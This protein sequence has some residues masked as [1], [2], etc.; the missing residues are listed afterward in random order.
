MG[1]L[2]VVY[3]AQVDGLDGE[4]DCV[5]SGRVTHRGSPIKGAT[6]SLRAAQTPEELLMMAEA[7]RL[8]GPIT[9]NSMLPPVK[10]DE[11]GDFCINYVP[12]GNYIVLAK[13][14]GYMETA[15]G[16]RTAFE[17][18]NIVAVKSGQPYPRIGIE[19]IAQGVITG[20]VLDCDGEPVDQ[21]SVILVSNVPLRGA[22]RTVAIRRV[23]LNDLGEFRASQL[24]PGLYYLHLTLLMAHLDN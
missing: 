4:R 14:S 3:A 23:P 12:S 6:I 19:L 13:K 2:T 17:S 24:P 11:H 9:E 1:I 16:A 7:R 5:I 22:Y 15:F 18:G 8:G 20:R 21:G 10:S